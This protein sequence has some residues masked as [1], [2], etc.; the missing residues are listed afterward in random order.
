MDETLTY[1]EFR[2]KVSSIILTPGRELP[3]NPR[4]VQMLQGKVEATD[5]L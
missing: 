1:D 3:G 4:V 5:Y 2:E